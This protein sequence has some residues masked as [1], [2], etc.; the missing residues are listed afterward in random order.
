[1]VLG[2]YLFLFLFSYSI[3]IEKRI[4]FLVIHYI[5]SNTYLLYDKESKVFELIYIFGFLVDFELTILP[6]DDFLTC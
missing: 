1:M 3:K 2:F 6:F 4:N 5:S